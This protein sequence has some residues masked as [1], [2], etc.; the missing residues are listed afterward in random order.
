MASRIA[1][2]LFV[3]RPG[4]RVGPWVRHGLARG[5]RRPGLSMLLGSPAPYSPAGLAEWVRTQIGTTACETWPEEAT[6]ITA[7]DIAA[8]QRVAFGTLDAPD[9]GLSDAVA[10]SSA[11]PLIFRPWEIDGRLYVDGGVVSGTHA[12]LVLGSGRPLDLV[13]VLA[14][15]AAEEDREGAWLHERVLDRVGRTALEE[16][17]TMIRSAWPDADVLVLRPAPQVLT[18][19]RPNPMEPSAAVPSFIRTLIS[20]RRTLARPEVWTLLDRHLVPAARSA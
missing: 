2:H 7:F 1:G 12:D 15:M 9:V 20:M 6:V 16:E 17:I 3:R 4:V 11:I 13:L 10:A 19:M 14:P 18:A 5:I 8:G